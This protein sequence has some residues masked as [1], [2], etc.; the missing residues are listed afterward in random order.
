MVIVVEE[1]DGGG[2]GGETMCGGSKSSSESETMRHSP[3]NNPVQN[4]NSV[5]CYCPGTC[6]VS[7][8]LLL[9]IKCPRKATN[10]RHKEDLTRHVISEYQNAGWNY[11]G[12]GSALYMQPIYK[13]IVC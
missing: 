9:T 4:R 7:Y 10:K 2:G 8:Y 6:T 12:S 13:Y 3:Q 5:S 1:R 11:Y